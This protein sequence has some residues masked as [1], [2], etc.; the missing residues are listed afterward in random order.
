MV[1]GQVVREADD[2]MRVHGRYV[3]TR[4][5]GYRLR[6]LGRSRT[7]GS[8]SRDTVLTGE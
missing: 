4:C 6:Q 5:A 1:C 7:L 8:S 2:R 3:H